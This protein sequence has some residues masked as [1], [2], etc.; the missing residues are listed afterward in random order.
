MAISELNKGTWTPVGLWKGSLIHLKENISWKNKGIWLPYFVWF[1]M[2][3][4]YSHGSFIVVLDRKK[5][6][7][8]KPTK[9]LYSELFCVCQTVVFEFSLPFCTHSLTLTINHLFY[10]SLT[11]VP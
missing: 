7:L 5:H 3:Q 8:K 1:L 10:F 6:A 9:Q 4:D 2:C 11:A